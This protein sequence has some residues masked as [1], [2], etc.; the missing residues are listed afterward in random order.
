MTYTFHLNP[1]AQFSDGTPLTSADVLFSLQRVAN[2]KGNPSFLV[3]GMKF[4]APSPETFTVTTATY[5]PAILAKLANP[6]LGIVNSKAIKSAGGTD[7]ANAATSDKAEPAFNKESYGSGPYILNSF[8]LTTSVTFTPNPKYWGGPG[9]AAFTKVVLQ[10]VP[11]AAQSND[12]AKGVS[13]LALDLSPDQ[14]AGISGGG[15]ATNSVASQYTFYLF[16]NANPSVSKWT[17]NP[18][19]QNAVRQG[20]DYKGLLALAGKGSQRAPG[21]IPVQFPGALPA[22]DAPQFDLAAAKASLTKSGYDGTPIDVSYP[23][24]LTQNGVSFTDMATRIAN[25]LNSVGI[26]TK[27][28]GAPITVVLQLARTGK[29]QIG[30]WLWGPDYPDASDY[31]VFGPG[32]DVGGQRVNWKAGSDPSIE[33]TMK[34]AQTE[35]DPAKRIADYQMFQQ[36]LNKGPVM[37]L[38]QPAQVFVAASKLRGLSYNLVWTVNIGELSY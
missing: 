6:S 30:V 31:L 10:N 15:V 35:T 22:S 19:F 36:Q 26:K 9:K 25:D 18:D 17:S 27:L 13:Q 34:A 32:G 29:Q 14:A 2:I 20:I 1:K 21:M 11:A 5:D 33:A 8:G 23:S 16:T 7:D 4:A 28:S 24:D 38:I 37:S 12:V 3:A